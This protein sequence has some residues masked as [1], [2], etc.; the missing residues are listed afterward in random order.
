MDPYPNL[1]IESFSTET[2]ETYQVAQATQASQATESYH[3][4]AVESFYLDEMRKLELERALWK[5]DEQ[6]LTKEMTRLN[7]QVQML[8]EKRTDYEFEKASLAEELDETRLENY[9]LRQRLNLKSEEVEKLRLQTADMQN[10]INAQGLRQQHVNVGT[11][12]VAAGILRSPPSSVVPSSWADRCKEDETNQR[13][14]VGPPS[15]PSLRRFAEQ[16][17][18]FAPSSRSSVF[19]EKI[20][21]SSS[22]SSQDGDDDCQECIDELYGGKEKRKSSTLT[23][24]RE[25]PVGPNEVEKPHSALVKFDEVQ[26]DLSA[27]KQNMHNVNKKMEKNDLE[28]SKL[29]SC[30]Q[31][32]AIKRG[33]DDQSGSS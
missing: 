23:R 24:K 25:V 27:L 3:K 30:V 4:K 13:V 5:K 21:L 20:V 17:S 9:S 18:D 16:E 19:S 26:D 7:D 12:A 28:I 11:V 29:E 1:S 2:M 32:L 6:V 14:G 8:M 15:A 31:T 33:K 10:K 22:S